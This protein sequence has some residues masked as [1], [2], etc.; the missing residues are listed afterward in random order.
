MSSRTK[1]LT[2]PSFSTSS[3]VLGV[4]GFNKLD[5]GWVLENVIAS[6]R[7]YCLDPTWMSDARF[8]SALPQEHDAVVEACFGWFQ[9]V[10]LGVRP[11]G[12]MADG[13][14]R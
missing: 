2:R 5:G 8:Q 4:D 12:A 9:S 13:H 3:T 1:E 7:R 14:T 11:M 6:A 10:A